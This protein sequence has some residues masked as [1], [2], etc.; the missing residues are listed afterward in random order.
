[1]SLLILLSAMLCQ[2]PAFPDA[3]PKAAI[4]AAKKKAAA[5][6]RRVLVLWGSNDD[7]ASTSAAALL[8]KDKGVARLILYE[9]DLVLA[10]SRQADAGMKKIMEGLKLPWISISTPDGKSNL[11]FETP[12]G[13][14]AMVELL[15]KNQAEP[16]KAKDVLAAAMKRAETGK[17]RV[18]LTFGAPW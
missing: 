2:D 13:S 16:L 8:K 14:K 11:Y 15:K 7:E 9:Y 4:E 3:D 1:M 10:D 17:K 5:E 18:L 6:N 12:A